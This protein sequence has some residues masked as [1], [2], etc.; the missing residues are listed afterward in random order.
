MWSDYLFAASVGEALRL[1]SEHGGEARLIAGGTDLLTQYG[2]G[3]RPA[4]VLVDVTRIPGLDRIEEDGDWVVLGANVTHAQAA[5][6]PLLQRRGRLL[7]DACR[8]IAGPQVR[9]VGTLT[10]N[11][12]TAL[13]AADAALALIALEAEAQVADSDGSYRLP[14]DELRQGGGLC[15]V[16]PCAEMVTHLRFRAL[17]PEYGSAHERLALRKVHALPIMNVAA[18]GALRDGRL[19]DV[20]IA[21]SPVDTRS[22][23]LC[24]VEAFLEGQAPGPEVIREAAARVA[25]CCHP[26][27]SLLRGA[28][29]YR[30]ALATVLVRRALER[31]AVAPRGR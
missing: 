17:G 13:P 18:V 22:L 20:R 6:S 16:N 29:E 5:A 10:G 15:R 25:F 24:E 30:L 8:I 19:H 3:K 7:A 21:I 11:L 23:R 26:R 14:V 2:R 31:V 28:G 9:N 1:L 27:D 12:I 4:R